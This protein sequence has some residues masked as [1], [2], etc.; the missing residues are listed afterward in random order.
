MDHSSAELGPQL[1]AL[2]TELRLINTKLGA[3]NGGV[4][5]ATFGQELGHLLRTLSALSETLMIV[6]NHL[7]SLNTTTDK[8]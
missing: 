3:F 1:D 8:S 6:V 4:A 5:A 2:L 7:P